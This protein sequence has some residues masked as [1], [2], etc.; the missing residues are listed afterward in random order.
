MNILNQKNAKITN[1]KY[2]CDYC[3]FSSIKE[4][5]YKRHLDRP[6]HK[7]NVILNQKTQKNAELIY[8]CDKCN[9]IYK[10]RNGLWYHNKT[11]IKESEDKNE[12]NELKNIVKDLMKQNN[13]L[14]KT[15]SEITPKIGNNMINTTNNTTFNLQFFLNEQCKDAININD[16]VNSLEITIDDL[17]YT[18]NNGLVKGITDV[19]IRGLKELDIYK[20]PIHCTDAKR[21]T[22]Y[23]KD[24]EKW[25]K[26]EKNEKMKE[27]ILTMANKERDAINE[28]K[29]A[30]PLWN[31]DEEKQDEFMLL[32][33]KVYTPIEEQENYEKKIIKNISKEVILEKKV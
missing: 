18:K 8:K 4:C 29:E 12:I 23:I 31:E 16:F 14:V 11:C 1:K 25:E 33:N 21:E 9:K 20:R 22:L 15:I 2:V 28:W 10:N 19:M 7:K 6:K 27:T 32:V 24:E 26:D 13:E 3:D 5:D 17:N 30:N